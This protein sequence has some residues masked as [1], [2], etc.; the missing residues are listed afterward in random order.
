MPREHRAK[1]DAGTSPLD[2]EESNSDEAVLHATEPRIDVQ[3]AELLIQELNALGI[4][5]A[6]SEQE[7]LHYFDRLA[8]QPPWIDLKVRLKG[9]ELVK[10]YDR[11]ALCRLRYYKHKLKQASK[12]ELRDDK[13]KRIL[14][15]SEDDCNNEFLKK[16]RFFWRFEQD[17]RFD[18]CFHPDYLACSFLDDYQRLVPKNHGYSKWSEYHTYL[19]SYE[20]EKEYVEYCQELSKQLKWMEPYVDMDRS[21]VKWGKI[22]SRGTLQAIKIAATSFHKI[23]S[24]LAFTGY[25]ECKE[26]MSY[27]TFWFKEY[28][29][30]YFEIWRRVTQG[31]SFEK[32]LGEV[33]NLN[34][35]PLRQHMMK[36]ALEH[37]EAMMM[38]EDE[39][40]T[41]TATITPEVKE[42]KAKEL[43]AD[44]VN[45]RIQ[46]PKSYE[47][48]IIKK[49]HI[50]RVIGIL[51]A[52]ED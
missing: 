35:F 43:I 13:L 15:I 45:K 11:H 26:S 47:E 52:D 32:A 14:D 1:D 44:A 4:G 29:G 51:D 5:E 10:L 9:E 24:C 48:Y 27:D 16:E 18:W 34:M 6:F 22:S 23:T 49:I 20:L 39:F 28:D 36:A 38:V 41:C 17:G 31:M 21:S 40:L 33:Y 8:C 30:V 50:A 7:F 46:K 2:P 37:E 25:Y 12:E 3:E 19:H 42:D